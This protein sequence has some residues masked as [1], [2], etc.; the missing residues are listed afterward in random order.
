MPAPFLVP[1]KE[2]LKVGLIER[3][4]LYCHRRRTT[5]LLT[6]YYGVFASK[7]IQ[8]SETLVGSIL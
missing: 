3:R 7:K 8:N 4:E 2:I 1:P 6:S 5:T